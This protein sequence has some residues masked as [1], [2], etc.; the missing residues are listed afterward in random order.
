MQNLGRETSWDT[1]MTE[2]GMRI[3]LIWVLGRLVVRVEDGW[4]WFRIVSSGGFWHWRCWT[5]GFCYHSAGIMS[6]IVSDGEI[7]GKDGRWEGIFL[8]LRAAVYVFAFLKEIPWITWAHSWVQWYWEMLSAEWLTLHHNLWP[9][10]ATVRH[11]SSQLFLWCKARNTRYEGPSETYSTLAFHFGDSSY[12]HETPRLTHM[13]HQRGA[14]SGSGTLRV[15]ISARRRPTILN[16]VFVVFLSTSREMRGS[17]LY[18]PLPFLSRPSQFI[19]RSHCTTRHY[20]TCA[21]EKA[22]LNK[23]FRRCFRFSS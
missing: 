8:R 10:F 5:F 15:G 21:V 12:C 17:T 3:T 14:G 16:A 6:V 11:V 20:L 18:R 4:N 7:S 1:W 22:L 23:W 9:A 19:F 2:K 13:T